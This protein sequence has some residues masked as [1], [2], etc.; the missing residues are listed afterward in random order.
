M[1]TI[2][3]LHPAIWTQESIMFDIAIK[4]GKVM[5]GTGN[6]WFRADVG[7]IGEK[8]A[9]VGEIGAGQALREIEA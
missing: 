5:E 3:E 6:P 7:I 4:N 1:L 2:G 8:I 9:F